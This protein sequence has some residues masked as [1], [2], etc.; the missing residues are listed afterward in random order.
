MAAEATLL[1]TPLHALHLARGWLE[2]RSKQL[3]IEVL[4]SPAMAKGEL[5][6]N[7]FPQRVRELRAQGRLHLDEVVRLFKQCT[8]DPSHASLERTFLDGDHQAFLDDYLVD[9]RPSTDDRPYYFFYGLNHVRD[10]PLYFEPAGTGMGGSLERCKARSAISSAR[11]A[12]RFM[13]FSEEIG[14]I[15]AHHHDTLTFQGTH[16]GVAEYLVGEH[17]ITGTEEPYF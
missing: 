12:M 14:M 2:Q 4:F 11:S 6:P 9:V 5:P 8:H 1:Y 7:P 10:L 13:P 15:P 3:G 16:A 17:P